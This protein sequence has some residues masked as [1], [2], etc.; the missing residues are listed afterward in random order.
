[1]I[2]IERKVIMAVSANIRSL[3]Q[4]LLHSDQKPN[5]SLLFGKSHYLMKLL[6]DS[7]PTSLLQMSTNHPK[8]MTCYADQ[9]VILSRNMTDAICDNFSDVV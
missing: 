1:V 3:T 5:P 6:T 4:P 9:N 2:D 8:N 7:L